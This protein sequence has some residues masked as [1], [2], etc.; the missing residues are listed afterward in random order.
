MLR[1]CLVNQL[2]ISNRRVRRFIIFESDF[3]LNI[4]SK[5]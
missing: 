1:S 2:K 5:L 3:A 4:T